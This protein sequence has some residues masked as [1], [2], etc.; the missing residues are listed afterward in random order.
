MNSILKEFWYGNIAPYEHFYPNT[1]EMQKLSALIE[2]DR[3]K[4]EAA[5]PEDA[6]GLLERYDDNVVELNNLSCEE[7]FEYAFS[8]GVRLTVA[9][10]AKHHHW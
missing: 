1:E 2:R 7:L 4:I 8:L 5:L 10:F 9:C 3:E 6:R